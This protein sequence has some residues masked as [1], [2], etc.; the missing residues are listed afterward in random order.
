MNRVVP[1]FGALLALS[2]RALSQ[3]AADTVG[4]ELKNQ[5]VFVEASVN[6]K[7][8]FSFILDTG[9]SVTVLRP[10]TAEKL[11]L[12]EKKDEPAPKKRLRAGALMGEG[13]TLLDVE[14]IAVGKATARK[15]Q[16]AVL[17]APQADV[18]LAKLGIAYDGILGYTFLSR[19]V[20]TLDYRAKTL[21]L[22]P[23]GDGSAS[24]GFSYRTIPDDLANEVG[25]EGGLEVR[26]VAAGG[27][28]EQGGLRKGDLVRSVN[29]TRI[30]TAEQYRALLATIKPGDAVTLK[31]VR[32]RKD[33]ELR[34]TAGERP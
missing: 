28:A 26:A 10:E 18:P 33:L 30:D 5:L 24:L 9:A 17:A 6:G 34:L 29:G 3:E 25:V 20:L 23:A 19:F 31:G 21:K 14:S 11:G 2:G 16:V 13:A 4:F 7:G 8:P 1:V 32:E 15:V 22:V 27:P 12:V